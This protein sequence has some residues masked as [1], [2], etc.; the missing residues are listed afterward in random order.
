MGKL[1]FAKIRKMSASYE[2][3]IHIL[4][5]LMIQWSPSLRAR[6]CRANASDPEAGS[7]KQKDPS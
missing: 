2:F 3:V 6:V 1:T 7:D 4:E 5:P